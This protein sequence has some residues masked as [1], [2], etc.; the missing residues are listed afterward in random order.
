TKITKNMS[1]FTGNISSGDIFGSS[2]AA[3]GDI[4]GDGYQDIA[5]GAEYDD[6]GG[7][8]NG[9][10]YILSLDTSGL[11]LSTQKISALSGGFTGALSGSPAFGC[12]IANIGDLNGDGVQDLAV[13]S[14]R[15]N[16][17]N[18]RAGAVWILFMNANGTVHHHKKI[19]STQGGLGV[20][21]G[22]E[23]YFGVTVENIGDINNDGNLEIA[24]GSHFDDDGGSNRGAIYVLSLDTGGTVLNTQKIS[25]S[26]GNFSNVLSNEDKFGVSIAKIGD[27][28]ND[29]II[30]I[31]VGAYGDNTNGTD[32]GAFYILYLNSNGSVKSH[33]KVTQ[34]SNNFNGNLNAG[35]RFGVSISSIGKYNGIHA[36]LVGARAD[37]DGAN[38]AGAAYVLFIRGIVYSGIDNIVLDDNLMYNNPVQKRFYIKHNR[39]GLIL[40]VYDMNGRLIKKKPFSGQKCIMNFSN[41]SKGMYIAIIEGSAYRRAIKI[42]KE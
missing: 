23:A 5:V 42:I 14:R 19:S 28:D 21:L 39:S 31:A 32:A 1:G 35:D 41:L 3:L 27:L 13:G 26:S 17:G 9:A 6:D 10:V 24:V 33:L 16:D 8:W 38:D 2:F 29:S 34:G 18:T 4:N 7:N 11:V 30:D 25:S 22:M 20:N 37:D 36:L 40:S 12:D 15:D